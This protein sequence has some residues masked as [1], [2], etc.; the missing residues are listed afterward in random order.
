MILCKQISTAKPSISLGLFTAGQSL[1]GT[2][3]PLIGCPPLASTLTLLNFGKC[4]VQIRVHN[5]GALKIDCD[6]CQLS[7]LSDTILLL[8][9]PQIYRF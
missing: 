6:D 8:P 1:S 9:P 4:L 2:I 5:L 3:S 7:S